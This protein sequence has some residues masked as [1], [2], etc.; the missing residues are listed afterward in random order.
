MT[1]PEYFFFDSPR[2]LR[3]QTQSAPTDRPTLS[4]FWADPHQSWSRSSKGDHDDPWP[5]TS[6]RGPN[7]GGRFGPSAESR[8]APHTA[9][10]EVESASAGAH[11]SA[12]ARRATNG[13][14]LAFAEL[15]IEYFDRVNRYLVIALKSPDDAQEVAQEVFTRAL[16]RLDRFDP[17]RGEF[18]DWLFSMVRSVAIDHLRRGARVQEV[19]LHAAPSAALPVAERAATL[20]EHLDPD[21]GVRSL[22]SALPELQRRVLTLRFVL[23]FD[24]SEIG[25][26]T[27]STP[28][29]IRHV[30]HRAL[31]ALAAGVSDRETVG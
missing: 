24:T 27:G 11:A 23:G 5:H 16:R 28:D 10:H 4:N 22:I 14:D 18:R 17:D 19:D 29:A 2:A 13:D 8:R 21:S 12:L 6:E 1:R 7:R 3:A 15:Y 30:Q 26:V 25:E 9:L 31:K 20:V